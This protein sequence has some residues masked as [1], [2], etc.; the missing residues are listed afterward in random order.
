MV[1]LELLQTRL[2]RIRNI[3]N[4]TDDFGDNV[5]LVSSRSRVFD[6]GTQFGLRFVDF[7]AIQMI[8]SQFDG[9]FSAIDAGLVDLTLVTSLIPGRAGA[10]AELDNEL[11]RSDGMLRK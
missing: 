6:R 2:Q 3:G 5:Q 8:I 1:R 11:V 9:R 7:G 10:V 4:V